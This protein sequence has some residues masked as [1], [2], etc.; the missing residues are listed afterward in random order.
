MYAWF[1]LPP[2]AASASNNPAATTR[3]G[4]DD[5]SIGASQPRPDFPA[6]L[7]AQIRARA[8][9]GPGASY[10]ALVEA[11][12]ESHVRVV[13]RDG[14][15]TFAD[16]QFLFD[17]FKSGKPGFN[18]AGGERTRFR[19]HPHGQQGTLALGDQAAAG[20]HAGGARRA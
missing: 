18:T 12:A 2:Q 1:L 3:G 16:Q 14:F 20:R 10:Q 15:R 4:N 19:V 7:I 9:N 11:A 6:G 17:G 8:A 13:L 5:E